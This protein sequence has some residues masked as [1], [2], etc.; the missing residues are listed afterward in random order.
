MSSYYRLIIFNT[1]NFVSTSSC[2]V[3]LERPQLHLQKYLYVL[4][5]KPVIYFVTSNF[6]FSVKMLTRQLSQ[7]HIMIKNVCSDKVFIF[8]T[9]PNS[10]PPTSIFPFTTRIYSTLSLMRE[11]FLCC[12]NSLTSPPPSRLLPGNSV[13]LPLRGNP[14]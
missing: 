9:T 6:M 14:S 4:S 13:F 12:S 1:V 2:H 11:Y 3:L 5:C 10:F 7:L 8:Y